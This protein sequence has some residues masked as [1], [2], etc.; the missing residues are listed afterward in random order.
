MKVV[1]SGTPTRSA[2]SFSASRRSLPRETSSH[3][4]GAALHRSGPSTFSATRASAASRPRP[5]ST[6]VVI[7]SKASG[8]LL[9]IALLAVPHPV[10]EPDPR[11]EDAHDRAH[12]HEPGGHLPPAGRPTKAIVK[13]KATIVTPSTEHQREE[14][15]AGRDRLPACDEAPVDTSRAS[16]SAAA[17]SILPAERLRHRPEHA[18]L[19]PIRGRDRHGSRS[20]GARRAGRPCARPSRSVLPRR[21]QTS[22]DDDR[23]EDED[24]GRMMNHPLHLDRENLA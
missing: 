23:R 19:S 4:D 1:R 9:R 14:K 22:E 12:A 21:G 18:R 2:I 16:A 8:R 20:P 10:L 7:R 3:R 24:D 5:A 6:Q 13:P 15:A 17:C 11:Q